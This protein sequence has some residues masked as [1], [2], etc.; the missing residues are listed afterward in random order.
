M[1][2]LNKYLLSKASRFT[3]NHLRR[4]PFTNFSS[5]QNEDKSSLFIL[6]TEDKSDT[7]CKLK[8]NQKIIYNGRISARISCQKN[9]E[10]E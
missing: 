5:E 7:K 2:K 8:I 3:F 10:M 9:S 1:L 6:E 4:T